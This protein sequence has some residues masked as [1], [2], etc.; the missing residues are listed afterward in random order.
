MLLN[1]ANRIVKT[2]KRGLKGRNSEH[3]DPPEVF[4]TADRLCAGAQDTDRRH[5]VI[6]LILAELA[7]NECLVL[8]QLPQ[9]NS[10]CWEWGEV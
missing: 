3:K 5:N 7:D 9:F 6:M 8:I 4:A 2:P 1:E 10:T